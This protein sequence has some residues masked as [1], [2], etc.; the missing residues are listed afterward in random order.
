MKIA[1]LILLFLSF[2]LVLVL[3]PT[4]QIA[5]ANELQETSFS[6]ELPPNQ[7]A[8]EFSKEVNSS[9]SGTV[10]TTVIV[11][12]AKV[13]RITDKNGNGFYSKIQ[14]FADI[15]AEES[16][17]VWVQ[18]YAKDGNDTNYWTSDSMKSPVFTIQEGYDPEE[19]I[20]FSTLFY[21]GYD[22]LTRD[23]KIEVY[24]EDGRL[25]ATFGPEDDIDFKE[26]PAESLE[27]DVKGN[28]F[29]SPTPSPTPT[30][31]DGS[32]P[33]I[34]AHVVD[35]STG[36]DISEAKATLK[37]DGEVITTASSDKNGKFILKNLE[38]GRYDLQVTKKG[39]RKKFLIVTI[40]EDTG[41]ERVTIKL[42]KR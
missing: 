42:K 5:Q 10:T 4:A 22:N 31:D 36:D 40:D 35:A 16:T 29:T 23:T 8:K 33:K 15:D 17:N 9:D 14:W 2:I 1:T 28:P 12:N 6:F 30:P 25:A 18:V 34:K 24:Y 39:Y 20:T 7:A 11:F 19:G 37:K 26:N 13:K 27:Y 38:T 41:T 3:G 21:S 32:Q